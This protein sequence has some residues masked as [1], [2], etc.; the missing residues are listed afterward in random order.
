M[1]P[2]RIATST[3]FRDV[4]NFITLFQS[5]L[6]L[7]RNRLEYDR[8]AG[9]T[10][11]DADRNSLLIGNRFDFTRNRGTKKKKKKKKKKKVPPTSCTNRRLVDRRVSIG[12]LPII[13]NRDQ[14]I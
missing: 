12:L 6:S 10:I 8:L 13:L 1:V 11:I 14:L 4:E 9:Q 7:N 3:R 2:Q 5:F